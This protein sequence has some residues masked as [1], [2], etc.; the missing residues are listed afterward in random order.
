M[1]LNMLSTCVRNDR[2]HYCALVNLL[3]DVI[4]SV[5]TSLEKNCQRL[6]KSAGDLV[7]GRGVA[8]Q[9]LKP[10]DL[11]DCCINFL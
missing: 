6:S 11:E 5:S 3:G 1:A 10:R 7:D 4:P 2:G 9:K 8:V